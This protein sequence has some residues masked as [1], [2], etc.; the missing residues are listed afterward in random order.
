MSNF[1]NINIIREFVNSGI[2][3][4]VY[5]VVFEGKQ[6]IFIRNGKSIGAICHY[7][8]RPASQC[9]SEIRENVKE[10]FL[11]CLNINKTEVL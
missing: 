5:D 8:D 10:E 2:A 11:E 9:V 6:E 1:T 3:C 4:G 7:L